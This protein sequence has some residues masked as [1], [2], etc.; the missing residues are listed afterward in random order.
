MTRILLVI[1]GGLL[2]GIV[3]AV[4]VFAYRWARDYGWGE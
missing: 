3:V 1:A 4:G 2:G